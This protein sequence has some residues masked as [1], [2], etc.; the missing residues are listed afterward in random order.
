[1]LFKIIEYAEQNS[2]LLT[3]LFEQVPQETLLRSDV[4]PLIVEVLESSDFSASVRQAFFEHLQA[5][6][7]SN[8]AQAQL[9]THYMRSWQGYQGH[10]TWQPKFNDIAIVPG[11]TRQAL[12]T[13][14]M[15]PL[16]RKITVSLPIFFEQLN[17]YQNKFHPEG[18]VFT[19][20]QQVIKNTLFLMS[21]LT[22][23]ITAEKGNISLIDDH[24]HGMCRQLL[25]GLSADDRRCFREALEQTIDDIPRARLLGFAGALHDIGKPATAKKTL[26]DGVYKIY[27]IKNAYYFDH[28]FSGHEPYGAKLFDEEVAKYFAFPPQQKKFIYELILSH[29]D[30]TDAVKYARKQGE[31]RLVCL[32]QKLQE[33][34][35]KYRQKDILY[36]ALLLF[37]ADSFGKTIVYDHQCQT[38]SDIEELKEAFYLLVELDRRSR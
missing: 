6:M 38:T 29:K 3:A 8:S 17:L 26:I 31:Q 33:I 28:K 13:R 23:L 15:Y 14:N 24:C 37:A 22:P 9:A 7:H 16:L 1:M 30:I 4:S 5:T 19:H 12:E 32:E 27:P 35:D 2:A 18:T 21:F 36:E 25:L 20:T 11:L 10:R 34:L